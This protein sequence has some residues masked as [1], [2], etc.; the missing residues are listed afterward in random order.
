[1]KT[2]IDARGCNTGP[3][4]VGLDVNGVLL[5]NGTNVLDELKKLADAQ[6]NSLA[7]TSVAETVT[8][9]NSKNEEL[10]SR[11][12]DVVSSAKAETLEE[13]SKTKNEVMSEVKSLKKDLKKLSD[14]NEELSKKLKSLE[15]LVAKLTKTG[16]KETA[17]SDL[18]TS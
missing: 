2:I 7:V 5:V 15:L 11:V 1:M 10:E 8:V 6:T 17:V 12:L 16:K 13:L 9:D 3:G 18:P 14:E 4:P